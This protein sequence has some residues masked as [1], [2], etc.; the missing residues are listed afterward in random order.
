MNTDAKNLNKIL[1]N[2][3]KKYIKRIIYNNQ[4]HIPRM[5]R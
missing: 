2:Q 4:V 1:G 5:Q 3:L